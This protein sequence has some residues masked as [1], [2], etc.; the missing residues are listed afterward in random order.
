LNLEII[1]NAPYEPVGVSTM[2]GLSNGVGQ[3]QSM[4]SKPSQ[5]PKTNAKEIPHT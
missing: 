1:I 4:N 2:A 3:F 5:K